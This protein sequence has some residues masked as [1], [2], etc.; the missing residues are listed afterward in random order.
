MSTDAAF[1]AEVR[2]LALA[3]GWDA[4]V[5]DALARHVGR[6]PDEA[7]RRPTYPRGRA[8][9]AQAPA[10][11]VSLERA[12]THLF[13]LP[14]NVTGLFR[15]AGVTTAEAAAPVLRDYVRASARTNPAAALQA[16]RF[17][18]LARRTRRPQC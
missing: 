2:R 17:D 14:A 1:S 7:P 11:A 3:C 4:R 6:K 9:R 13:G 16:L 10:A 5:A 12:V 8:P 15:A 18:L